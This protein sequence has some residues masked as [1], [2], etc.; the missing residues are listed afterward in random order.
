MKLER[1]SII[2]EGRSL[3]ANRTS[4]NRNLLILFVLKLNETTGDAF[5]YGIH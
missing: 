1:H 5:R 3:K 4:N 2:E